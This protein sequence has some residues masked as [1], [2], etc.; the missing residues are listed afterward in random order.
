[1]IRK[2]DQIVL[3]SKTK[4]IPLIVICAL[5]GLLPFVFSDENYII[6]LG[7]L[8]MCFSLLAVSI[9]LLTGYMGLSAYGNAG[10][11]GVAAYVAG[12]FTKNT[13]LPFILIFLIAIA[14]TALVA[15]LFGFICRRIWGTTFL[16]VN[17]TLGQCIWGLAFRMSKITGGEMGIS[18]ISRPKTVFGLPTGTP[19]QYYLF[20]FVVFVAVI[21]LV[22]RLVNSPFGLTILGIRQSR[23]R[24]S[25]LGYN[26]ILHKHITYVISG[27][28]A[29]I[30]GVLYVYL[31]NF[32]SP[33]LTN[34]MMMSK[35]FLM[36][37]V[38][39][40]GTISGGVIGA[41]IIVITENLVSAVTE[42]WCMILGLLYIFVAVVSPRG[43]IGLVRDAKE[44]I[45][46]FIASRKEK[47]LA[48]AEGEDTEQ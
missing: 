17:L 47:K 14:G 37:L 36:S 35:A 15:F 43:V 41:A 18:G 42:R 8:I 33:N 46:G 22:Y 4:A 40:I 39:G 21:F 34:S 48:A 24:M 3:L 29:G 10:F 1:M 25:A 19:F 44:K 45:T 16:I 11:F 27:T 31:I 20:I 32:V 6:R 9:D 23:K 30:G 28:I 7:S 5:L 12:W 38:G 2:K 26:V 13:Q